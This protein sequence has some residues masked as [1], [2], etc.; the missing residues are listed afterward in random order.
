VGFKVPARVERLRA[1]GNAVVPQWAYPIFKA[2]AEV[3]GTAYEYSEGI[4]ATHQ[5]DANR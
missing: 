5:H 4:P 3:E 1:L 2:I